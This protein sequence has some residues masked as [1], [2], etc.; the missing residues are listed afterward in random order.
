M[1]GFLDPT[2]QNFAF[3]GLT[4]I[5]TGIGNIFNLLNPNSQDFILRR[6]F[7]PS[8]ERINAITNLVKGKF[9]FVDS[10]KT[11]INALDETINNLG[12]S[13]RLTMTLGATQY[14]E[15]QRVVVID[16]SWYAPFKQ[17]G[18]L[19]L[20]GFIYLFFLWRIFISI[21]NIINGL[22]G[23]IH[24]DVMITD[25]QNGFRTGEMKSKGGWFRR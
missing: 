22:G 13:P 10:I 7:V 25:I 17:Y 8:E 19:V 20:T 23:A 1:F 2:S 11:G 14:T 4:D 5:T 18:D 21:P 16:L 6:A 9:A 24:A 3:S 15:E 12:S